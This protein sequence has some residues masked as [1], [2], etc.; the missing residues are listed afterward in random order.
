MK[1]YDSLAEALSDL[2]ARGYGNDLNL[3]TNHLECARLNLLLQPQDFVVDEVHRLNQED[4]PGDN[5]ILLA[6]T[7]RQGIKGV[8][9]DG[10]GAYAGALTLEMVQKLRDGRKP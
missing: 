5:V 9:L 8:L 10:Y 7:S 1:V 6:I 4:N 3:H 2:H